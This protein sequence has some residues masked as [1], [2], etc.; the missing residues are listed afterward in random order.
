M[1]R[2]QISS[3]SMLN[4]CHCLRCGTTSERFFPCI[5]VADLAIIAGNELRES[6]LSSWRSLQ[7][8]GTLR[9]ADGSWVGCV[10]DRRVGG[11]CCLHMADDRHGNR[12]Q[13][14]CRLRVNV[15]TRLNEMVCPWRRM[16]G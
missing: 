7:G 2:L 11:G 9:S 5:N 15:Q 16:V 10:W 13:A 6:F 14:R 4:Q 1:V 8:K 3:C 12:G